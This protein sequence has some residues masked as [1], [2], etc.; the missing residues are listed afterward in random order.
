VSAGQDRLALE[1][2]FNTLDDDELSA[3]WHYEYLRE[4]V[5]RMPSEQARGYR[6]EIA[7]LRELVRGKTPKQAC[8]ILIVQEHRPFQTVIPVMF[9]P[10]WPNT[11]Y[12]AILPK[13]QRFQRLRDW[14]PEFLPDS[15][16]TL[17]QELWP[18][19]MP[20][21]VID[22]LAA[23]LRDGDTPFVDTEHVHS[24]LEYR[25]GQGALFSDYRLDTIYRRYLAVIIVDPTIG[26]A[27]F[28]RRTK[29]L[30]QKLVGNEQQ[31]RKA[32]R[33]ADSRTAKNRPE[34]QQ[35]GAY[36]MVEVFGLSIDD[37]IGQL[38]ERLGEAAYY[39]DPRSFQRAVDEAKKNLAG[40]L[41]SPDLNAE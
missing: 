13:G 35:L 37:A 30:W 24:Q 38:I 9:E 8:Q 14:A 19:R 31:T 29:A 4:F 7:Q 10:E 22:A 33:P 2:L 11:P 25:L 17:L 39:T 41:R 15:P 20:E 18:C 6:R 26:L 21:E 36:R 32:G 28:Q 1:C 5:Q 16:E 40:F 34:L 23:K 12:Q 27:A 3:C